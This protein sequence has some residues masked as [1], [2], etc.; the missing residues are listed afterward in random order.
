M[1]R[2]LLLIA[3]FLL[4]S[5][6]IYA[7]SVVI[8]RIL[9]NTATSTGG[10]VNGQGDAVELLILEDHT[11]LRGVYI[12]DCYNTS[13]TS[14]DFNEGSRW[15][16]TNSSLWQ[17]LRSGTT[18]TMI[19]PDNNTTSVNMLANI[20]NDPSDQ[21]LTIY[22]GV[23]DDD[24][25][26]ATI[27]Q[28]G[29]IVQ[30]PIQ[31]VNIDNSGYNFNLQGT[32]A[33]ILKRGSSAD[34]FNDIIHMV[35]TGYNGS[36]S[37]LKTS[38]TNLIGNKMALYN[39]LPGTIGN[40]GTN[41]YMYTNNS[42]AENNPEDGIID[43]NGIDLS[44]DDGILATKSGTPTWGEGEPT[45]GNCFNE[46]FIDYLRASPKIESII[47]TSQPNS[48]SIVFTVTFNKPITGVDVNDFELSATGDASGTIS[49]CTGSG[50]IY[51]V[52]VSGLSGN[53]N[54]KLDKKASNTGITDGTS[55]FLNGFKYTKG[56]EF[57]LGSTLPVELI[58]FT[59]KLQN[60]NALLTW[61]TASESNN[62]YFILERSIDG[63]NFSALSTVFPKGDGSS[64]ADYSFTDINPLA[65]V[66]YYRL[67]QKDK[68]GVAKELA[69]AS[70]NFSFGS[71]ATIIYPNP[72]KNE[73]AVK[74]SDI[75]KSNITVGLVSLEGKSVL[76][77]DLTLAGGV[78][79]VKLDSSIKPGN[80]VVLIKLGEISE[81]KVI[82][83]IP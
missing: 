82:T 61:A 60:N 22:F 17:D 10:S 25:R 30:I 40:P 49:T 44:G 2:K 1:K 54:I 79:T 80:Y 4:S 42:T 43:Y 56:S 12:K 16:F 51:Q 74:V 62:D 24:S 11:D 67:S 78:A 27:L 3:G 47:P 9:N 20:D 18:I 23:N 58:G 77:Q 28:A 7:Q 41:G 15:Q 8:N 31:G 75:H 6:F 35:L 68:D 53:G 64:K 48:T 76:N 73:F 26:Y 37:S 29:Y 70:V 21:K 5:S 36:T 33:V 34:G 57:T 63:E 65:G 14:T 19:R 45:A 59:A 66:S 32:D 81:R 39:I 13:N 38:Y 72:V 55:L 52:T 46:K 71:N 50:E 69:I 83:I